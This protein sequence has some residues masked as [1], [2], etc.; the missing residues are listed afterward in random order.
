[1]ET[2]W[3]PVRRAPLCTID[4]LTVSTKATLTASAT[5]TSVAFG[6]D[7]LAAVSVRNCSVSFVSTTIVPGV[8]STACGPMIVRTVRVPWRYDTAAER[9]STSDQDL[10][11]SPAICWFPALLLMAFLN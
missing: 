6:F 7:T 10:A 3:P 11:P 5:A 8:R 1:M 9:P 4:W 2:P